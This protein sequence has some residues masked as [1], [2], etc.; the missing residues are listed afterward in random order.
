L[1]D[2]SFDPQIY[3]P[4]ALAVSLVAAALSS[5]AAQ[6]DGRESTK[7]V[8]IEVNDRDSTAEVTLTARELPVQELEQIATELSHHLGEESTVSLK[9]TEG[10][11]RIM[12]QVVRRST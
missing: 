5:F 10:S 12:F 2:L 6:L 4:R 3:T 11:L 8:K 9:C 1:P 7:G